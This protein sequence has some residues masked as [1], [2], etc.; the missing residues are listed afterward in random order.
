[1]TSSIAST[2]DSSLLLIGL[3]A[4]LAVLAAHVALGWLHE[5]QRRVGYFG[6]RGVALLVAAAALG[7]GLCA[8]SV[9]ALAGEALS[10]PLGYRA[11]QA[12][13]LWLA[14]I[15]GSALIGL[16]LLSS[17]RWWAVS[18]A[19]VGLGG[20]VLALHV[21][22]VEA[23]GLRPGVTWAPVFVGVAGA[24]LS[25]GCC[26]GLWLN[27]SD[28]GGPRMRRGSWRTGAAVLIGLS[29]IT[30]LEVLNSGL[31]LPSQIG[32]VYLRQLPGNVLSLLGGVL[33]PLVLSVMAIDLKMRRRHRRHS[34]RQSTTGSAPMYRKERRRH[35]IPTI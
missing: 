24:L 19:G 11:Q 1:M 18:L 17:V 29:I 13:L 9:L 4:L 22:W 30:G 27:W 15:G 28:T 14:A 20:L 8:A 16:V 7:S 25:V 10:F 21:G 35:K 23:A 32:S 26:T 2:A 34:R 5:A 33:L 12:L 3:A 6:P 31:P